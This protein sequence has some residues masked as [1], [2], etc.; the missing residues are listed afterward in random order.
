MYRCWN[1]FAFPVRAGRRM[2]DE[3]HAF[4]I[5]RQVRDTGPVAR[6]TSGREYVERWPDVREW[7]RVRVRSRE[8]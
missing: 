4:Q 1:G 3:K 5:R 7:K 2:T 6:D 8:H